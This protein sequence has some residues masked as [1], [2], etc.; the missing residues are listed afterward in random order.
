LVAAH[1]LRTV[2]RELTLGEAQAWR[3]WEHLATLLGRT[4]P[5][6]ES[7]AALEQH[8]AA[9][10]AE[11]CAAIRAGQFDESEAGGALVALLHEQITDAL[12]V[13]NPEFLARVREETTR[14]T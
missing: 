13:W 14:D 1:V 6:P 5:R 3:Q 4:E 7:S 10:N 11:L 9:L 2:E 12:E 8:L